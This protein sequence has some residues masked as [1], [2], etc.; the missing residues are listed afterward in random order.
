LAVLLIIALLDAALIVTFRPFVSTSE[1][2]FHAL[3]AGF[4]CLIAGLT[5]VL[6]QNNQFAWSFL[7]ISAAAEGSLIIIWL[8]Y[9]YKHRK[10]MKMKIIS[11]QE[12]KEDDKQ[13]IAETEEINQLTI[14]A[15]SL[16]KFLQLEEISNSNSNSN[17]THLIV[18]PPPAIP[19]ENVGMNP[20]ILS[21]LALSPHCPIPTPLPVLDEFEEDYQQGYGHIRENITNK[22]DLQEKKS[23]VERSSKSDKEIQIVNPMRLPQ[24]ISISSSISAMVES[25]KRRTTESASGLE[26][27]IQKSFELKDFTHTELDMEY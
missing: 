3:Q 18:E 15:P 19:E 22:S 26:L 16:E 6:A 2:I 4:R 25:E 7:S 27:H 5:A 12:T 13:T 17:S 8:N 11:K 21:D 20:E 10:Q 24:S 14:Q 9:Q 23:K 1:S